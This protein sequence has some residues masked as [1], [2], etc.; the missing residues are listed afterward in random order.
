V[1][2]GLYHS[3]LQADTPNASQAGDSRTQ[4][5]DLKQWDSIQESRLPQQ[6]A[7]RN[8]DRRAE[9]RLDEKKLQRVL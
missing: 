6:Q 1:K 7:V 8:G 9:S 4:Q 3:R 2:A 5:Q